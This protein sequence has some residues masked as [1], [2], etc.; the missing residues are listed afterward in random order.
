MFARPHQ[1]CDSR[2]ILL[3][4]STHRHRAPC[5]AVWSTDGPHPWTSAMG[6]LSPHVVRVRVCNAGQR[7]VLCERQKRNSVVSKA[8]IEAVTCT[9]PMQIATLTPT[10][11]LSSTCSHSFTSGDDISQGR[12][13]CEQPFVQGSSLSECVARRKRER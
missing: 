13:V 1:I 2:F 3:G 8:C 10:S 4:M 12:S 7:R 9:L 11:S 6:I 5:L